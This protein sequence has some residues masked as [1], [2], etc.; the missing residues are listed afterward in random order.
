MRT[1]KLPGQQ[2]LLVA[3]EKPTSPALGFVQIGVLTQEKHLREG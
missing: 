1:M 2:P 3:L